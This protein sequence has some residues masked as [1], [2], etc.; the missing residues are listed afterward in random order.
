MHRKA[1]AAAIRPHQDVILRCQLHQTLGGRMGAA[2]VAGA[3]YRFRRR[4]DCEAELSQRGPE[5]AAE[6]P[7][8]AGNAIDADRAERGERSAQ[9]IGVEMIRVSRFGPPGTVLQPIGSRRWSL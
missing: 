7:Y 9:E 1:D 5:G 8:V 3:G 2:D 4:R 6:R